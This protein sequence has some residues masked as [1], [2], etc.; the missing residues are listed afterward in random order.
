M[1]QRE[2]LLAL[3]MACVDAW[4]ALS[5]EERDKTE[6]DEFHAKYLVEHGAVVPVTCGKCQKHPK[7]VEWGMCHLLCR[8]THKDD[9]CSMGVMRAASE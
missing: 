5:Q 1:N 2:K 6:Y 8:Q 3:N 7:D 9:Y 4:Y